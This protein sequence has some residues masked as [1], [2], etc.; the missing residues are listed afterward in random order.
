MISYTGPNFIIVLSE[1][2]QALLYI[3]QTNLFGMLKAEYKVYLRI[4]I[5]IIANHLELVQHL[6]G[7]TLRVNP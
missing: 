3:F 1:I 2:F 6:Q 5:N 4:Y 7:L